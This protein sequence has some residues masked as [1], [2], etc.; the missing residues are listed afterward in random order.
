MVQQIMTENLP[1]IL[2]DYP[3]I[4]LVYLFGSQVTGNL[5]PMSDYDIAIY[6]ALGPG[7]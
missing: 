4:H 7:V 3:N 2:V 5:G 1:R 6:D